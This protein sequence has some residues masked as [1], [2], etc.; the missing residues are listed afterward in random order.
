MLALALAA[1]SQATSTDVASSVTGTPEVTAPVTGGGSGGGGASGDAS[2]GHPIPGDSSPIDTA[3]LEQRSRAEEDRL[4]Y[5][6]V[7]PSVLASLS[8]TS[9]VR[10]RVRPVAGYLKMYEYTLVNTGSGW[11][12]KFLLQA[13]RLRPTGPRPLVVVFHRYGV[14]HADLLNSG[15][16]PEVMARDWFAICPLGAR[17]RNFGNL[18]SQINIEVALDLVARLYPIDTQ[19]VYG[20]GFSMGGG[21]AANYA[22]RHVDPNKIRFAAVCNHTG[23]VSLAHTWANE[24]DDTDVG[25]NLPLPGD[26]L[27]VPD[28]LE[29]LFGGTPAVAPFAY[30]RCSTIDLDPFTGLIGVDTDFSRNLGHVPT[31]VWRAAFDPTAYLVNQT[32]SFDLH[33]QTQN[34]ANLYQQASSSVHAWSSLDANFV[35]N[36]FATHT[37]TEPNSGSTLADEDGQWFHF[38]VEQDASGSF[39]PF[40]WSVDAGTKHVQVSATK[41]LKRLSFSP[42]GHGL[43]LSGAVT[44]DLATAD[45]TGDEFT[46][47]EALQA[48]ISVTRDG[49]PVAGGYDAQAKT[50]TIVETDAAQHQWVVTFP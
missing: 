21:S 25:D 3:T 47:L 9:G 12:E 17:Q 10:Y 7:P 43:V 49:V 2:V 22:A 34:A 14:S 44:I 20:V 15:F 35:C 39:T 16:L 30:Q 33:V 8:L 36:W 26:N 28:V 48:P 29:D 5:V 45:A 41:N 23:S 46:I 32:D 19:R 31:L 40:T 37:L 27:E 11:Q 24:P 18:E 42:A 38:F 13:P 50:F 4:D 1:C 6:D